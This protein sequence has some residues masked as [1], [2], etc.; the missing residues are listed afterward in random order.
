MKKIMIV[1]LIVIFSI[2][3]VYARAG[4]GGSGG[5]SGGSS[6]S[7]SHGHHTSERT[8]DLGRMGSL[9]GLCLVCGGI[10]YLKHRKASVLHKKIK[11]ELKV[12]RENDSFWDE[13]ELLKKVEDIY[14]IVQKAWSSQDTQ[15]LKQYL[16]ND[17][18]E[19]WLTKIEWQKYKHEQ[20][21]LDH[22]RLNVAMVVDMHDDRED[23]KDYFWVYIVG[24]MNDQTIVDEEVVSKQDDAFVEYWKFQ[25]DGQNIKLADVKQEDEM[26]I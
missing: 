21:L 17:L 14:F 19:Q 12:A 9:G 15:T 18:Y 20:N 16:T 6:S 8:S 10:F 5:S 24:R 11:P 22:I 26:N 7:S 13:K 4:G 23:S 3:P 25:R 1:I 2:S